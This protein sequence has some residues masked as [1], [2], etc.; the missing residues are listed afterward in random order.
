[1]NPFKGSLS[2]S[3]AC[4]AVAN[5]LSKL[6]IPHIEIPVGDG[7]RG[8]RA[9]LQTQWK[10]E[11]VEM[12]ATSAMGDPTTARVLYQTTRIFI[13]SPD[14]C[15]YLSPEEKRDAMKAS[16]RG[17]GEL[18][19]QCTQRWPDLKE[20]Y[21]GLG[22][23]AI[24]DAGIGMLQ[25]LGYELGGVEANGEGLT[26]I[27][28]LIPPKKDRFSKISFR[29][30]CDVNNPLCGEK[31]SAR[32]FAPQK[33]AAP[34]Q[35]EQLSAG[36]DRFAEIV[37]KLTGRSIAKEPFT[38]SAGGLASAFY[39]LLSAKLYPGAKTLFDLINFD[40]KLKECDILVTGEGRTDKQTLSG[41]A[42]KECL[43][44]AAK[45]GKAS[46]IISGS[47]GEGA[48]SIDQPKFI[49]C[50]ASGREPSAFEALRREAERI[51]SSLVKFGHSEA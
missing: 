18:L 26:R 35:V 40:D 38:G 43:D 44:R 6:Q 33:G 11:V 36:M 49:G 2:N 8:T 16:S 34:E 20:I 4:S 12:P 17:L 47:L 50:F 45:L 19:V 15:G 30:L 31:G 13:E 22:D 41:K 28:N 39:G 1:M 5:G 9:C 3:E 51:F 48:D 14:V 32:V 7:G 27:R 25:A 29:I 46:V 21:V 23:S 24:S 10:A 37:V 42:P